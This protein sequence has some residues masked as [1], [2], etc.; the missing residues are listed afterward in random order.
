M[1]LMLYWVPNSLNT[2]TSIKRNGQ[3]EAIKSLAVS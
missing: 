1:I 2:I 3:E